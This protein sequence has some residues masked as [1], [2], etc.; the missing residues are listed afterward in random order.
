MLKFLL[1][2]HFQ[3]NLYNLS[4]L[5]WWLS[6]KEPTCRYKRHGFDPWVGKIPLRRKWQ[7]TAVFLP[8]NP[9]DRRIL[10][11]YNPWCHKRVRHDL[12]SKQQ[13]SF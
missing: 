9:I 13:P 7:L 2:L 1:E 6:G 4:G 5:S 3:I 8:G 11:G 12:A 10:K